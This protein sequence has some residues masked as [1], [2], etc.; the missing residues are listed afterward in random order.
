MLRHAENAGHEAAQEVGDLGGGVERERLLAGA[1][2]G[3][4]AA[5]FHGGGD[6]ALAGDAL[7]DNDLGVAEGLCGVAAFLVEG[8]GDVV[9]PFGMYGRGAGGEGLFGVGDGGKGLVIDLDEVGGVGRDVAIGG[10]D[11]GHGMADVVDA[12]LG[13]QVVVG[14]A[15]AGEGRGAGHGAEGLDIVGR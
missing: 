14:H 10:D 3:D 6:E 8:E 4:D 5:G 15:Q 2:F 7:F 9:G 12:V 11:D 1:P 13:Q